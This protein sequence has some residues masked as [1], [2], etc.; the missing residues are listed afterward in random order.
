MGLQQIDISSDV[1]HCYIDFS[2]WT[3]QDQHPAI[4]RCHRCAC[5]LRLFRRRPNFLECALSNISNIPSKPEELKNLFFDIF[6]GTV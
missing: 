3:S 6:G 5:L 2:I 1:R 4:L